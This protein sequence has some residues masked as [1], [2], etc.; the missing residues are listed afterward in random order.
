M[1]EIKLKGYVQI[2]ANQTTKNA[3]LLRVQFPC[4]AI[5]TLHFIIFNDI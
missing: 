1:I 2:R 3:K 4:F 5:C